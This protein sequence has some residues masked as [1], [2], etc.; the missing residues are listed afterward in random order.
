MPPVKG[1]SSLKNRRA[2]SIW[3]LLLVA[4][5]LCILVLIASGFA[6]SAFVP[7]QI[8]GAIFLLALL[9]FTVI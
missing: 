7:V 8:A 6:M 2:G 9:I 3:L 1:Q 4:S 5:Q